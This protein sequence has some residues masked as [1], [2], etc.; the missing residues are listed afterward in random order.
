MISDEGDFPFRPISRDIS[1]INDSIVFEDKRRV[2]TMKTITKV[3]NEEQKKVIM[4][5]V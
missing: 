1:V 2:G 4:R 3:V 5:Y